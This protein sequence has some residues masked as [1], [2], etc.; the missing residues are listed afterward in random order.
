MY[1]VKLR[2][3]LLIIL[4]VLAIGIVSRGLVQA[5]Y[6]TTNRDTKLPPDKV[7]YD[8]VNVDE[9][10][11][12]HETGT[13]E[14]YFRE[15][16]DVIAI[17]DKRSG[18]T[19]KTGLDI[20]FGADINDQILEAETKEEAEKLAIPQ[21]EG[22][23]TTYTGISNSILT[24][25]YYEEGTIKYMSSAS[26]QLVE[27]QL[28]TLNDN[29]A[30]RRLDVNFQN[31]E[32]KVKVH[33]T[34][35]Q[36]SITYEI[37]DEDITGK[38]KSS[39]A[40]INITPFLGASGGKTKYYNP[41]TE[42]YD[43]IEDKYMIPGYIFVPDGSGALIRFQ[44]NNA[45]FSMYY[46]DVYGADPSQNTYYAT[47]LSDA[48]PL[49]DPVIPVFGVAHGDK[50]AAFVAYADSGAEYMQIA[51]RPEEN[52]TAYNYVYPRFVYNVNYFQV[53]NKKA[54][55]Y[56]TLMDEPNVMD[57]NMTYTF[58]AGDGSDGTPAADYTGMALTYR[59]HLIEQGILNERDQGHSADIPLRLDF[60]MADSKKGIVG[61]E[62]VVVTTVEDVDTMLS[63]IMAKDITNINVGL[64]GWQK[65]GETL[66]KPYKGSFSRKIGK[67]KEFKELIEKFAEQEV[68]IS[69]ARDFVTI[70]REMINFQ[71]NAARHIN[72]WYL[73]LNKEM[74]L[75]ENSP[76][77]EFGYATPKRS[78]EWF[79]KIYRLAAPYS[80]SLTVGGISDTLVS[81]YNRD[82]VETTVTEAIAIYQE[83][84]AK[85]KENIKLNFENPNMYLWKYTDR[86]LQSPVTTSQYVFETD[87]VPFLQIVLHGTMEVYAP[88]SNF[89]FYTQADILRMIDY[90]LSPS[91]ILSMEPSYHLA[92]TPS[93]NLYSTEFDQ[94]E[95]RV[96]EVYS[97]V[98]EAL[99]QVI[100][101]QWTG[102]K[103]LENGVILN[104]YQDD[105]STKQIIINYTEDTYQ[106]GQQGIAPLSAFVIAGQ[107]VQ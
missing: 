79:E 87:T 69:Y 68:D 48:I 86:Y 88:Y 94:Y 9:Y 31:I 80:D 55:G 70:N 103:V 24:V 16:R 52:L 44:D 105:T 93:S 15:D 65:G 43:I 75:P 8:I 95:G 92:S 23:N 1:F 98:N 66:A 104:T 25:E 58:L 59:K 63:Q 46:G 99:S 60:I 62:E 36:D 5:A 82:G 51:V 83:V 45:S 14:Y 35:G 57:I 64:Y 76:V 17:K 41:E 2:R 20:P 101:Y 91:F 106:Y 90:N 26:R 18:Y 10:E 77:S 78:A 73:L 102:R 53:Y 50:Q 61:T 21:E 32:L 3:V 30:T 85:C 19:W 81:N 96:E 34:L 33:I 42:M 22:M 29:P 56:F 49:K 12:L 40:A 100:G 6:L 27:S 107:E 72:S 13:L 7:S 28:V 97:K 11:L 54:D 67:E 89:S 47:S 74:I 84:F 38:G 4:A 37:K 71:S 39:L